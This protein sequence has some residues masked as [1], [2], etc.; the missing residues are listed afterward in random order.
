MSGMGTANTA[1]GIGHAERVSLCVDNSEKAEVTDADS[2]N[3]AQ[4]LYNIQNTSHSVC[5]DEHNTSAGIVF[6]SATADPFH[7]TSQCEMRVN[8]K[9]EILAFDIVVSGKISMATR[10][11]E[12]GRQPT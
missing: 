10:G 5:G 7:V 6:L 11:T 8:A 3:V 4:L 9:A 1:F 12:S 2:D